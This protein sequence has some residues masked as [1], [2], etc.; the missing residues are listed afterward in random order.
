MSNRF[1]S[2]ATLGVVAATA[3]IAGLVVTAGFNLTPFGYAQQR[4]GASAPL[5]LAQSA[6]V[7]EGGNTFVS[8]AEHVTPAVVSIVTER[9]APKP[10]ARS[11]R[12]QAVPPGMED[13]FRQFDPNQR[14]QPEEGSGSGFIVT[15]D[16]YILTNNHVVGGRRQGDRHAA[17][18]ADVQ[19]EGRRPRSHDRCRGDQDRRVELPGHLAGR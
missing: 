17:R 9:N 10:S 2:R 14:Q 1:L 19:G 6:P 3:F 5:Q 12:G 11:P 15:P 16:G 13:F 18:Q 8:I 4:N 7:P